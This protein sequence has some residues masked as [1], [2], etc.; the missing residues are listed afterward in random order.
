MELET[1]NGNGMETGND[2]QSM[3][4]VVGQATAET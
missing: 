1:G 2:R 4:M 3:E